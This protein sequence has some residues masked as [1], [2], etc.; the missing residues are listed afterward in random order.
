MLAVARGKNNIYLNSFAP[1]NID[2]YFR[3]NSKEPSN[4]FIIEREM[5][6]D[7]ILAYDTEPIVKF[8]MLT[9]L[10]VAECSYK[11]RKVDLA[12]SHDH[13]HGEL[14]VGELI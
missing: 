12:L 8:S 7:E 1:K 2:S 3:D 14:L 6:D 9:D 11:M 10:E 5:E 13:F 4:T